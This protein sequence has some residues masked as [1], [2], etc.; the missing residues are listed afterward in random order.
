MASCGQV[1]TLFTAYLDGEAGGE[2]RLVLEQHVQECAECRGTLESARGT[3]AF[4]HDT[5]SP[6]R[7][8]KD[9]A[10][11]VMA[12]LPEM[13]T[14]HA[15]NHA[16][17]QR[18]KHPEEQ[19]A[20][21]H[22]RAWIPVFAPMLVVVLGMV[23]W[24][25]WSANQPAPDRTA[26]LVLLQRG[27]VS[28]STE[29]A[30]AR[31]DVHAS[32]P[33]SARVRYETGHD[34]GLILG[35][36]GNSEVRVF[37]D[38]RIKVYGAREFRL[39]SGSVHCS[40]GQGERYFRV[41]TPHGLVTVF[42]TVFGVEVL[43]DATRVTVIKGEVQVENENTFTVLGDGEQTQVGHETKTLACKKVSVS[44]LV[45]RAETLRPETAAA[46]AFRARPEG[47]AQRLLRAEQVFVVETKRAPVSEI[48]LE[49]KP[50]PFA[51][52]HAGYDLYVSD[53]NMRPLFKAHVEPDA[54][55]NKT[56][57]D[58]T[59]PV[60]NPALLAG[61]GVLHI[62]VL[63]DY[64]TGLIETSFTEVAVTSP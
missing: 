3:M 2:E 56:A 5:L 35:L 27:T 36:D 57:D 26:G 42:G 17:T 31:R 16:M 19:G 11:Q 48:H 12:H 52:N 54:F 53:N 37:A 63:P 7:L 1:K 46:R 21:G 23:L 34:G 33:V 14:P 62:S 47:R 13:D 61:N 60:P 30:P 55:N 28:S 51:A 25:S 38:S 4:L 8:R 45:A 39:E 58:Y 15:L 6:D 40:V 64:T 9:L 44:E 49:W 32:D 41:S 18:A 22:L 29:T 43:D 10:P 24:G 50:D 20:F 59:V